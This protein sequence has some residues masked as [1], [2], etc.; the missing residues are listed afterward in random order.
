MKPHGTITRII[1][2]IFLYLVFIVL[3]PFNCKQSRN[4]TDTLEIPDEKTTTTL[5][6]GVVEVANLE[7]LKRLVLI[8]FQA[9]TGFLGVSSKL[10]VHTRGTLL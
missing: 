3:C 6:V 7:P 5:V 8:R 10:K 9:C 2:L 1:V 4:H